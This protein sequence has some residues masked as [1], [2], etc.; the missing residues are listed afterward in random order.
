MDPT[1]LFI[2]ALC[3]AT[4]I[5]GALSV[6]SLLARD[7]EEVLARVERVVQ[8]GQ[9]ELVRLETGPS[10]APLM[11]SLLRPFARVAKPKDDSAD[12]TRVKQQLSYAGYRSAH[13]VDLFFGAKL[14]LAFVFCGG[15][16]LVSALRV[17]P[18]AQL[19]LWGLGCAAFGFYAPS[20]WLRSRVQARQTALA[21]ALPDTLDLLVTCVEAGLGLDAALGRISR[22]T[23]LSSPEL[24]TELQLTTSEIQVGMSRA[25]AFRRLAD[26]TGLEELRELSAMLIQTELFG[27]SIGKALRI[28]AGSM[29]VR[30]THRAEEKAATVAVK[31]LLPLILFLLP[32]LFSVILGP[33]VVRIVKILLPALGG[34]R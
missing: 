15:I 21:R 17:D 9:P 4:V 3:F 5:A 2:S 1:L 10:R 26:R 18:L 25:E 8:L 29:R 11:S 23:A 31:M 34:G 13:A 33:A 24:A 12:H 6:R 19:K 30:R 22:E 27:T 32:S 28:H 16:L 14:L 7:R 20:V